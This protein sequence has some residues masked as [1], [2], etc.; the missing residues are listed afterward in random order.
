[1][2]EGNRFFPLTGIPIPKMLFSRTLLADCEPDPF[3]VATLMLKSLTTRFLR[4][5]RALFLT[6]SQV[7]C[8]HL[9]GFPSDEVPRAPS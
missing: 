8:R 6:Q 3:T 7:S 1:M 5:G 2:F 4:A 9:A